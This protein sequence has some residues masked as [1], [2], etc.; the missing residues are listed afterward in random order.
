MQRLAADHDVSE[1][2]VRRDLRDLTAAGFPLTEEVGPRGLKT[3]RLTY[4]DNAPALLFNW[5]EALAL[6]LGRR[7]LDPLAGTSLGDAAAKAFLKIQTALGK[8]A[9]QYLEKMAEGLYFTR[10]G[11]GD[12]RGQSAIIDELHRGIADREAMLITYQS[13]RS[14]E[15]VE[16]EIHP[17]GFV[18]HRRS[19]YLIAWSRD[20]NAIRTFKVDRVET[21]RT[22][23]FP[24]ERPADFNLSDYMKGSFGVYH[25]DGEFAVRLRFAPAV[26]RY[27]QE[28]RWHAS[29]TLTLEHDGSLLAE[30]RLST[31]EE[32]KSWVLGFGRH[33]QALAP[34][35]LRDAIRAELEATAA[36]YAAGPPNDLLAKRN[37]DISRRTTALGSDGPPSDRPGK[38]RAGKAKP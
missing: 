38:R 15:P 20:S 14:T 35:E 22:T 16:Y 34:D 3:W 33:V 17:Y 13:Q 9:R 28:S 5:D 6:Y 25:G 2:T 37:A 23:G 30:F 12:Y 21:A 27:V 19:M 7:F 24:F 10:L 32:I 18:H 29:Q 1:K 8:G 26:A 11:G 31:I 36:H 4:P